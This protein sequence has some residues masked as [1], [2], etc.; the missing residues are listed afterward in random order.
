MRVAVILSLMCL[1]SFVSAQP[2]LDNREGWPTDAS[3]QEAAA[4]S[5]AEESPPV[6]ELVAKPKPPVEKPEAKPTTTTFTARPPALKEVAQRIERFQEAEKLARKHGEPG[7]ASGIRKRISALEKQYT[8][9][10]SQYHATQEYLHTPGP[11]GYAGE[12]EE[13]GFQTRG[14]ADKR[15]ALKSELPKSAQPKARQ[16]VAPPASGGTFEVKPATTAGEGGI[17]MPLAFWILVTVLATLVVVGLAWYGSTSWRRAAGVRLASKAG[18]RV[19]EI[20]GA[21]KG[22]VNIEYGAT[23]NRVGIKVG[24]AG[25]RKPGP[26]APTPTTP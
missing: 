1:T 5:G 24:A 6:E 16:P 10:A 18:R 19:V 4:A 11:K 8:A 23:L 9:L 25:T 7:I 20:L 2:A 22:P 3:L 13:M 17:Q 14:E 15:Y 12:L 21:A 26:T